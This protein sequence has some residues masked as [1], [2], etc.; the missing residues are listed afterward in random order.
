MIE[1][2]VASA[3]LTGVDVLV[4]EGK[5]DIEVRFQAIPSMEG[6]YIKGPPPVILVC[7]ERPPGRQAYTCA[8]ELGHHVFSHGLRVDECLTPGTGV[9]SLS[10]EEWLADRF[11]SFFLMP[12][13]VVERA[14][15]TR[16]WHWETCES[17]AL[18]IVAGQLGVGYETLIQ[19]MKWSLGMLTEGHAKAHLCVPPGELRETV[20]GGKIT[21]HLLI[22]DRFWNS[23]IAADLQVGDWAILPRG[24]L[25]E[26]HVIRTIG[27][28]ERGVLVEARRPGTERAVSSDT[29]W[30]VNMR[31]SRRS[32][33]GRSL[34]R[35]LEDPDYE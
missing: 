18:Y 32:Y 4:V 35:H 31:V 17:S 34:F 24:T 23:K 33:V 20:L 29:T 25:T 14:F 12:R 19:H 6:M 28:H 13:Y 1:R 22:V 15:V 3:G 21:S 16:G 8:H 9:G 2:R 5:L 7:S 27:N 26:Q 30:A 10:S 11:A